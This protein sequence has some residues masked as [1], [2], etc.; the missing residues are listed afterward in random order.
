VKDLEGASLLNLYEIRRLKRMKTA[1]FWNIK[2]IIS[3]IPGEH[4]DKMNVAFPNHKLGPKGTRRTRSRV[5]N[6]LRI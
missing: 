2:Y 4:Q 3:G 1:K 5:R 6:R